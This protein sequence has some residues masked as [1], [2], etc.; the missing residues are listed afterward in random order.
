MKNKKK[1]SFRVAE[2]NALAVRQALGHFTF[3][4]DVS[5]EGA[6]LPRIINPNDHVCE[7]VRNLMVTVT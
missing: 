3:E 7:G 5:C 2:K 6:E 4:D 1:I